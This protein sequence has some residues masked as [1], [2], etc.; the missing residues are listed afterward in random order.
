M[1]YVYHYVMPVIA[2]ISNISGLLSIE[3]LSDA[4]EHCGVCLP[5]IQAER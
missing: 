3:V 4:Q 1:G 5:R 2:F